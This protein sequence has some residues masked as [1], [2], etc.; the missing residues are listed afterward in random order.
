MKLK[1][2]LLLLLFAGQ[3]ACCE[4]VAQVKNQHLTIVYDI[5]ISKTKKSSGIEETYNGGT[6][7]VFISDNKA[8][9]RMVS[10]MRMES[11]FFDYDSSALRE[12]RVIKESGAKKYQYKLTAAEW[13]NYNSKYVGA[14]CDT[15]HR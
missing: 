14:T 11:I 10:L 8:R 4:I 5:T 13:E 15:L 3:C 9:I 2:P 7:A 1:L 12:A 6:K